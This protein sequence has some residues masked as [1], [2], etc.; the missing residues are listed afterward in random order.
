VQLGKWNGTAAE[1][2]VNG[3]TAGVI[4]WQPYEADITNAVRAGRNKVEVIVYGSLKNLLGPHHGRI[5]RGL[6]SPWGFRSAPAHMPAASGYDLLPYGLEEDFQVIETAA[7][8]K[9]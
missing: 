7:P 2:K 3:N 5:N 1:V 6:T 4:G 8:A 9:K